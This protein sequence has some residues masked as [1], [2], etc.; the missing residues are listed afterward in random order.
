MSRNEK[1]FEEK[2]FNLIIQLFVKVSAN[3]RKMI[4]DKCD[5][6]I[7]WLDANQTA[8]KEPYP[9]ISLYFSTIDILFRLSNPSK[10]NVF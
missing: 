4:G 6:T 7:K 2:V 10:I 3:N 9:I 8:E 1:N 5:E